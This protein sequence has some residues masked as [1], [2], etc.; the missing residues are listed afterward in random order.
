[1]SV[2]SIVQWQWC[3]SCTLFCPVILCFIKVLRAMLFQPYWILV[4]RQADYKHLLHCNFSN[5]ENTEAGVRL[6]KKWCCVLF[7]TLFTTFFFKTNQRCLSVCFH[8]QGHCHFSWQAHLFFVK[9]RQCLKHKQ[10]INMYYKPHKGVTTHSLSAC[11]LQLSFRFTVCKAGPQST[12]KCL[13]IQEDFYSV[14]QVDL[15]HPVKLL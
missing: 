4:Y 12:H 7:S 1:M 13:L 6:Q 3:V 10:T 8:S 11:S 2:I 5:K 14:R 15:S 9:Q